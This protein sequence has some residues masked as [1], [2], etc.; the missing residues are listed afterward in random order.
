MRGFRSWPLVRHLLGASSATAEV[1]QTVSAE[2]RVREAVRDRDLRQWVVMLEA[3]EISPERALSS[4]VERS[5]TD[6]VREALRREA[7]PNHVHRFH[8][9][10]DT[11]HFIPYG[12]A[13]GSGKLAL[14]EV[15]LEYGLSGLHEPRRMAQ[16]QFDTSSGERHQR[17]GKILDLVRAAEWLDVSRVAVMGAGRFRP[18]DD[19]MDRLLHRDARFMESRALHHAVLVLAS[20]VLNLPDARRRKLLDG[21]SRRAVSVLALD[22]E[23]REELADT[24][25]DRGAAYVTAAQEFDVSSPDS[26]EAI[27]A[28]LVERFPEM[29]A[30]ASG[31][32]G[33][34]HWLL[35]EVRRSPLSDS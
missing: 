10:D 3:E 27:D 26:S 2:T 13:I 34:F 12:V 20:E 14:V 30:E 18:F 15:F 35:D 16:V 29:R 7:D 33:Y 31:L 22:L 4:A 19:A 24:L 28:V 25:R 17:A 32:G 11:I 21:A 23:E 5:W 8:Y 1:S 6:G 9:Q